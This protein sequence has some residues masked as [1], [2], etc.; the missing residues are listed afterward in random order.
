MPMTFLVSNFDKLS[1]VR[2]EQ[3]ENMQSMPQTFFVS[4]SVRSSD[5]RLAHAA[6]I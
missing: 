2:L 6:N 4:K 5:V 3:P 1:D